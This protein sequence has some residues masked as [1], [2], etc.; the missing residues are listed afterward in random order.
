M[1]SRFLGFFFDQINDFNKE[2]IQKK[3]MM[4][5]YDRYKLQNQFEMHVLYEDNIIASVQIFNHIDQLKKNT[6]YLYV[7]TTGGEAWFSPKSNENERITHAALLRKTNCIDNNEVLASGE[8]SIDSI[9]NN[10]VYINLA[11]GHFLPKMQAYSAAIVAL[12]AQAKSKL[13][14]ISWRFED[15]LDESSAQQIACDY[16]QQ[17]P[18]FICAL[19][20]DI[21][22]L[23]HITTADVA[24]LDNSQLLL[25]QDASMLIKIENKIIDNFKDS[26]TGHFSR[27]EIEIL[28]RHS[29]LLELLTNNKS[30][31]PDSLLEIINNKNTLIFN[32]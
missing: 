3:E 26:T 4:R 20:N 10:S 31:C 27:N 15:S 17:A 11:S 24:T 21:K 7:V 30:Y 25:L 14:Y 19:L 13:F 12:A 29:Y 2:A 6:P 23:Q 8:I 5:I 32:N 1:I 28:S 9:N 22:K 16:Y 18:T